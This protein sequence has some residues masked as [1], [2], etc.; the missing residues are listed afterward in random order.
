MS[1]S[2]APGPWITSTGFV[3]RLKA[4]ALGV[5][6]E[7]HKPGEQGESICVVAMVDRLEPHDEANARLIA[8]APDLLA[9]LQMAPKLFHPFNPN[10]DGRPCICSQCKFADAAQAAIL[11][12]TG[13]EGA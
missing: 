13:K 9:A 10:D 2:H 11:K 5:L 3:P 6:K 1:A 7:S 8:A 12:A 4:D